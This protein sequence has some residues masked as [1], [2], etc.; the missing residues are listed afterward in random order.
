MESRLETARFLSCGEPIFPSIHLPM[1]RRGE[2]RLHPATPRPHHSGAVRDRKELWRPF[3]GCS[4]VQ[5]ALM[6]AA[7]RG[8]VKM[9]ANVRRAGCAV[10][11]HVDATKQK[12]ISASGQLNATGA[13]AAQAARRL[14]LLARLL[15]TQENCL[16]CSP[17]RLRLRA[18]RRVERA[19]VFRPVVGAVRRGPVRHQAANSGRT[20]PFRPSGAWTRHSR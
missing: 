18:M 14:V 9:A 1:P 8:A 13:N 20:L 5:I 6:I 16:G 7:V 3:R 2:L 11:R 17:A 15:R 19:M 4:A 12:L 10:I